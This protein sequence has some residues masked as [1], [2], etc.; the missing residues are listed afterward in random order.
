MFFFSLCSDLTVMVGDECLS[1]DERLPAAFA[2]LTQL[3][4]VS[5]N[6]FHT[7]FP[8]STYEEISGLPLLKRLALRSEGGCVDGLHSLSF[9]SPYLTSLEVKGC[10]AASVS[11]N[12]PF[13]L[14]EL[15][16]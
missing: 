12:L 15:R 1:A 9:A 5:L 2:A 13:Y 14:S 8:S 16:K 4:G 11:L 6:R 3:T 7:S 10:N